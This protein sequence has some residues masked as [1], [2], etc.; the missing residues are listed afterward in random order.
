MPFKLRFILGFIAALTL[1]N[2]PYGHASAG[3]NG[4]T[5]NGNGDLVHVG[6]NPAACT[7]PF[8]GTDSGVVVVDTNVSQSTVDLNVSFQYALPSQTYVVDIRCVGKVGSV[9]TDSQGTGTAQI[10]LPISQAPT[11]AFYIDVS[12][13]PPGGAGSGGYGDTFIA[14]PFS[15][16]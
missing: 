10:S 9:T 7:G 8:S 1:T 11:G 5:T 2:V 14:G 4:Q 6:A 15:L 16:T 13:A 12:V 3:N